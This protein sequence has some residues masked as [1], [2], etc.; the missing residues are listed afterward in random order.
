MMDDLR[1]VG[2]SKPL[3]YLPTQAIVE[4][5]GLEVAAVVEES[6]TRGLKTRLF[7]DEECMCGE[8]LYVYDAVALDGLLNQKRAV[9]EA[10]GWP[11]EAAPFVGM[12]AVVEETAFTDL[13]NVIANAFGRSSGTDWGTLSNR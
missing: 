1:K 12:V 7:S 3:G 13:F 6:Q 11:T 8:S 9:L 5:C 2:P 10:A 4:C